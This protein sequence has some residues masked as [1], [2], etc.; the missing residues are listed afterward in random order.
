M[1]NF[2]NEYPKAIAR[3]AIG[4]IVTYLTGK[5][6][7]AWLS[8]EIIQS[9]QVIIAAFAFTIFGKYIRLSKSEAETLEAVESSEERDHLK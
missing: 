3:F 9:A 8:P 5:I 7:D 1:D 2:I 4:L 6:P